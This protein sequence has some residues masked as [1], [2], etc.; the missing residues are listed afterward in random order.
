MSVKTYVDGLSW[1][2]FEKIKVFKDA[3]PDFY[4]FLA[5]PC[6]DAFTV[7][8]FA[9]QCKDAG[10]PEEYTKTPESLHYLVAA[11]TA[12]ACGNA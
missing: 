11:I 1:Q 7:A 12:R 10:I 4:K 5:E 2:E 6:K 8:T 3:S 9:I